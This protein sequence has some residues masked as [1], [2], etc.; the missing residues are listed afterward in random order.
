MGLLGHVGLVGLMSLFG[1]PGG[2][3]VKANLSYFWVFSG[4]YIGSKSIYKWKYCYQ[5][6]FNSM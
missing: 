1:G 4:Y 6:F 5:L 3:A 2:F